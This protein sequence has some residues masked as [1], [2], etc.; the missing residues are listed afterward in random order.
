MMHGYSS[1]RFIGYAIPTSPAKLVHVG[2]GIAGQYLGSDDTAKDIDARMGVL[3]HAVE[4]AKVSLPPDEDT[5]AVINLFMAPEFFFHGTRGPYIYSPGM[6]DPLSLLF[7]AAREAFPAA[8]Y[9]NWIFVLGSAVTA[10][11]A[12]YDKVWT[13][14]AAVARNEI[15]DTLSLQYLTSFGN[16]RLMILST[17]ISFV[18]T[19]HADPC[20]EVRDR[21]PIFSNIP[22]GTL[23]QRLSTDTMTTEKY[24]NS[25]VDFLLYDVDRRPDVVTEQMIAYPH[26]DLSD[27]DLKKSADD[28]YAIFRLDDGLGRRPTD[29]GI[30]ICLDHYDGR[31]RRNLGNEPF[32]A[33]KNTPYIQLIPSCGMTICTDSVVAGA[34]GFVFNCDGDSQLATASGEAYGVTCLCN[35]YTDPSN[36][37][38]QSHTQLARVLT[39]ATG[40]NPHHPHSTAATFQ[41][42]DPSSLSVC[43]VTPLPELRHYFAGGPGAV[44]LYG[45]YTLDPSRSLEETDA[46]PRVEPV[47]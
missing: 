45:P 14:N 9:P 27:G 20:L 46:P 8:A 16:M 23:A 25:Y 2:D 44:H 6:E 7:Q 11:V 34:G 13:S 1:I 28:S 18:G 3:R 37:T 24:Y 10:Q 36:G 26:I 40:A 5:D 21:S 35:S 30:E 41:T 15:V 47:P 17:L 42:I 39:P 22:L 38:Y 29:L 19:C 12:A 4:T 32:P 33:G 43:P 31:L